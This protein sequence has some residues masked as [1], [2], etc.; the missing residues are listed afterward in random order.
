VSCY[1]STPRVCI[2]TLFRRPAP[3]ITARTRHKIPLLGGTLTI[4]IL[5][6]H[7]SP[8]AGGGP[9]RSAKA[10]LVAKLQQNSKLGK[11][12]LSDEVEGLIF[13]A[14]WQPVQGALGVNLP[15]EAL[16]LPHG[17]L[18]VVRLWQRPVVTLVHCIRILM[19]STSRHSCG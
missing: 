11:S 17:A 12:Y 15:V 8:Q 4:S 2:N 10:R 1:V 16:A 18:K 9:L 13:D 6:A 3:P 5:E 14:R 19:I 7:G